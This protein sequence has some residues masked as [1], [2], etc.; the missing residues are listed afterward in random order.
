MRAKE[1]NL[2]L[3]WG[4]LAGL[5]WPRP[6]RPRVIC[7]H[8]W[9][10]NAASFVPLADHLAGFDLLA[11]D[12]AGH[13]R[14]SHRPATSRYYFS[15]YLY[16][17]DAA[18]EI[19]GWDRCHFIGHSMGGGLACHLAAA[20]PERVERLVLLDAIGSLTNPAEQTAQRLRLSCLSVRKEGRHGSKLRPY[21]TVAAAVAARRRDSSLSEQAARL[22]CERSLEHTGNH[23]QWSTDPRLN[24]RSPVLLTDDQVLNLLT[25]I[26]APVLAITS[27][28]VIDYLGED[29]MQRRLAAIGDCEHVAVDGHHHF[30]MDQAE[31]IEA[32]ISE[33]LQAA[34]Q[35]HDND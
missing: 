3:P 29:M 25:A 26:R 1:I 15:E 30:H 32:S 34:G 2:P 35:A 12:F 8:G 20:L 21:P 31:A 7:L 19:L 22:L 27:A 11:L 33:F 13:G 6:G 14:S 10:D 5:H 23:Y 16:D 4:N 9:L 17:L 18:L 24:W 28:K